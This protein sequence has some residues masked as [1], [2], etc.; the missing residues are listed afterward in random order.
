MDL[1]LIYQDPAVADD[2]ETKVSI[3]RGIAQR[4]VGDIDHWVEKYKQAKTQ[5][6]AE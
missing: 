2:L 3:K 5:D 1:E 6:Q 4:V